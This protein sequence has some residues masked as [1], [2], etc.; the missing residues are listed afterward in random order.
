MLE[1]LD[2]KEREAI[3]DRFSGLA[4]RGRDELG[5]FR[6]I[7]EHDLIPYEVRLNE[8]LE[9]RR[10]VVSCFYNRE[11]FDDAIIHDVLRSHPS[12]RDRR[13][14]LRQSILRTAASPDAQ[15]APEP[16]E[17]KRMRVRWWIERLRVVAEK[18]AEREELVGQLRQAQKLDAMGRLASGVAHDFNNLLTVIVG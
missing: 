16:P 13:S 14:R 3:R 5:R 4:L 7:G 15:A 1:Y 6:E 2:L 10:M 17:F 9:G 11:R 12:G 8:F 18:E